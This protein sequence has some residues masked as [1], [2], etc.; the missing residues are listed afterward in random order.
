MA[1]GRDKKNETAFSRQVEHY[2]LPVLDMCSYTLRSHD[3]PQFPGREYLN[4]LRGWA[5]R[6]QELLARLAH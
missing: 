2:S 6:L 5:T 4:R 3:Q 1:F